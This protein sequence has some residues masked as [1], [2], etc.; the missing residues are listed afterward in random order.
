M[1]EVYDIQA[2]ASKEAFPSDLTKKERNDRE[3]TMLQS[4]LA[5]RFKM[6]MR[7]DP[8][9]QPVYVLVVAGGGPKL[10]RSQTKEQDCDQPPKGTQLPCHALQGGQGR[11]LHGDAVTMADVVKFVQNWTDKPLVDETG[12]T[13]LYNVQTEGWV[14]MRPRPL[15]PD[16]TATTGRRCGRLRSRSPDALR[17]FP[18]TRPQDGNAPRCDRYVFCRA[19]RATDSELT[20]SYPYM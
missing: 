20:D 1:G 3:R 15:G 14:P 2:T 11:G 12:L 6:K 9:D 8:T 13:A 18:Q 4:L 17:C 16:G 7:I 10:Q 5:D 19:R